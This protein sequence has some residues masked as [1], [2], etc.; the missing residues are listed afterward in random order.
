MNVINNDMSMERMDEFIISWLFENHK[1]SFSYCVD[2]YTE[3]HTWFMRR[4]YVNS[5]VKKKC[6]TSSQTLNVLEIG[7]RVGEQLFLLD[8]IHRNTPVKLIL[9]GVDLNE[10]YI[11]TARSRADVYAKKNIHFLNL[12][13]VDL[14]LDIKF[15]VIMLIEVIEHIKN[16]DLSIIF[17]KLGTLLKEDGIVIIS[18]PNN[19]KNYLAKFFYLIISIIYFKKF[20]WRIPVEYF[21]H[22]TDKPK[23]NFHLFDEVGQGHINLKT[24]KEWMLFFSKK[25][26]SEIYHINGNILY[27]SPLCD[28]FPFIYVCSRILDA[29]LNFLKLKINS[30]YF[31]SVLQK[32]KSDYV[33]F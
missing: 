15:D 20:T 12:N 5:I 21:Q 25:G 9:Y 2:S 31:M 19:A 30:S 4:K 27:G 32:K 33:T 6:E 13:A 22:K 14:T 26:F 17:D 18:V 11:F 23:K 8:K 1:A 24:C 7:C 29:I 16:E 10:S 3:S 28:K